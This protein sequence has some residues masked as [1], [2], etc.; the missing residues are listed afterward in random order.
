MKITIKLGLLLLLL[1]SIE[2]IAVIFLKNHKNHLNIILGILGY[3]IIG[4][5][6]AYLLSN[7]PKL[8]IINSLWQVLNII[9]ISAIGIFFFKEKLSFKETFGLIFAI[10]SI[11]LFV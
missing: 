11:I 5:I 1:V 6:L 7:Y 3:T 4:C 8:T 2:I 9:L 10:I